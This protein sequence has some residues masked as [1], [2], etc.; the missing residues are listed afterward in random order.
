V[1]E[2][3]LG[4]VR[5]QAGLSLDI[6]EPWAIHLDKLDGSCIVG[7]KAGIRLDP[8]GLFQG[9]DDLDLE[10]SANLDAFDPRLHDLR[11]N[12]SAYASPQHHWVAALQGRVPLL[13]TAELALN[14]MFISEGIYLSDRLGREV[15]SEEVQALSQSSAVAL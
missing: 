7:P 9:C 5:L 10:M 2:L 14:T 11:A 8:F 3:G 15:T 13:P 1:E 12:A 4:F 6:I